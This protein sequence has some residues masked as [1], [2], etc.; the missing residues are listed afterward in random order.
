M[1]QAPDAAVSESAFEY[2]QGG[3]RTPEMLVLNDDASAPDLQM[4]MR[5]SIGAASSS[6][7]ALAQN[8]ARTYKHAIDSLS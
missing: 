8:H 1:A 5:W 2:L 6:M 4:S 3:I 7:Q